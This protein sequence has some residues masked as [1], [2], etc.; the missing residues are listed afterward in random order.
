MKRP[1]M[2]GL[3]QKWKDFI[4]WFIGNQGYAN[5]RI[6]ECE[7]SFMVYYSTNR[8]HDADNTVPKFIIDGLCESGFIVDDDSKH[9]RRITLECGVDAERPRTEITVKIYGFEPEEE[10]ENKDGKGKEDHD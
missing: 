2:N 6:G 3:K 10:K 5:L 7:L 1:Q 8:R 4:A 9:I